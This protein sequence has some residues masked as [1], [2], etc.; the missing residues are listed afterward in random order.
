MLKDLSTPTPTLSLP[1][2]GDRFIICSDGSSVGLIYALI[3]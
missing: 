2:E 3:Q 1:V